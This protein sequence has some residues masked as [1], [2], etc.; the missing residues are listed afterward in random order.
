MISNL[1]KKVKVT[2]MDPVEQ[3][4]GMR[5]YFHSFG[6]L[7]EL[8]FPEMHIAVSFLKPIFGHLTKLN[9]DDDNCL[10]HLFVLLRVII[11]LF[12]ELCRQTSKG[13]AFLSG[14]VRPEKEGG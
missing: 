14:R 7:L 8:L 1:P 12:N 6:F 10:K 4:G 9:V 13:F 5:F 11:V 2:D 3:S